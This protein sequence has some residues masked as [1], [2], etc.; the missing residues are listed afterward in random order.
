MVLVEENLPSGD[1]VIVRLDND[2]LVRVTT[3][4]VMNP[5]RPEIMRVPLNNFAE[6]T[7]LMQKANGQ[8][9]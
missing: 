5:R 9:T 4:N 8:L 2:G 3:G 1:K 6:F 7:R